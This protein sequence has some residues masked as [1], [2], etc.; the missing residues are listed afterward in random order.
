M[1]ERLA[2]I[3]FVLIIAAIAMVLV[4]RRGIQRAQNAIQGLG[5]TPGILT[6]VY[7]WSPH[8]HACRNAQKPIL[9]RI[10]E[11]YGEKYLQ[12][13]AYNVDESADIAKAWG[14]MTIPTTFIIDQSGEVLFVNSGLATDGVLHRQLKL[15]P[16]SQAEV[17]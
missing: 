14:V 15:Q 13:I 17:Q 12:L 4:R 7:F 8:C 16:V 11:E 10:V 2:I 9:E 5:I 6:I 1:Y 3:L